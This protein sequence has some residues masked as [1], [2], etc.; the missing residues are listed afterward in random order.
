MAKIEDTEMEEKLR[1][2][3]EEEEPRSL[4]LFWSPGRR[5][6]EGRSEART[7]EEGNEEEK[8][9]K[10]EERL[11]EEEENRKKEELLKAAE[12]GQID[13]LT[14]L[15]REVLFLPLCSL[16]FFLKFMSSP[17]SSSPSPASTIFSPS[18]H[19]N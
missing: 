10:E 16:L 7:K 14:P 3:E 11:K 13:V 12:D 18:C 6:G 4:G 17:V 8:R 9:R 5:R 1:K 2:S 19:L 15:L